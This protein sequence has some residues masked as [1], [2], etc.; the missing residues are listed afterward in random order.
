LKKRIR[1]F[2]KEIAELEARIAALTKEAETVRA[3]LAD[4]TLYDGGDKGGQL[5]DLTIAEARVTAELARAEED[6]LHAQARL[7]ALR[8]EPAS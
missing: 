7:D 2:E 1:P 8:R 4:P 6:W 5:K 3:A